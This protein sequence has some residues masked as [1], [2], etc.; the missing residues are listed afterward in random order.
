RQRGTPGFTRS[1]QTHPGRGGEANSTALPHEEGN[2]LFNFSSGPHLA[3]ADPTDQHSQQPIW[4]LHVDP[5]S[6]RQDVDRY[7]FVRRGDPKCPIAIS[8]RVGVGTISD[9]EM[10]A[11]G[12]WR[13][14]YDRPEVARE[15]VENQS[16]DFL[17]IEGKTHVIPLSFHGL[18]QPLRQ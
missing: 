12:T 5:M 13:P 6:C 11:R 10:Q 1:V 17:E 7:S 15:V 2:R 14:L 18:R 3:S 9:D 8:R 16:A 4:I